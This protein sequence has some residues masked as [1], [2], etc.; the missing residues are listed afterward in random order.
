MLKIYLARHGQDE[1]NLAGILNGHRDMPL[2]EKGLEQAHLS[3]ERIKEEGIS[4]DKIYASPLQ[5]AYKTAEIIADTLGLDNPEV[6][7]DLIERNLGVMTGTEIATI[8]ERCAPNILKT[9]TVT[10]FLKAEGSE[11]FSQLLERAK[12][13]LEEIRAK[14]TDGNILLVAHGD[15]GKMIYAAYYNLDWKKVLEQFHFGNTELLELSED[16]TPESSHVFTVE[17]HN[18]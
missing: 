13:C 2:T 12:R 14:H 7:D 8:E 16:S 15:I 4:F 9:E 1:D 10:Y 11:D 5:R 6:L 17:Q 18:A 3:A